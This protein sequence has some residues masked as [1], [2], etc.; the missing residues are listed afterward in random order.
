MTGPDRIRPMYR[1]KGRTGPGDTH[2]VWEA[3][4]PGDSR[5]D[6]VTAAVDWFWNGY[7][8]ATHT[9]PPGEFCHRHW[10][11]LCQTRGAPR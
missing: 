2:Y 11:W 1:F 4:V 9:L 7:D 10:S 5:V 3:Y 6:R 8:R